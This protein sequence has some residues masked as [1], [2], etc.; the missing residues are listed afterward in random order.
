MQPTDKEEIANISSLN[1]NKA[2]GPNSRPYRILFFIKN[3]VLFLA[4]LFY[5]SFKNGVFPFVLK[6]KK[7]VLIFEADYSNYRAM[8]LLSNIEKILKKLM[9]MRFFTFFLRIMLSAVYSLDSDN[10]VLNLMP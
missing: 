2:S 5:T 10:S 3:E 8:S 6:T 7:V 4:D 1:S 9:Y